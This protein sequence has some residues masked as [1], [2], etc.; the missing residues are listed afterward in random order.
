MVKMKHV[1]REMLCEKK[2]QKDKF[3]GSSRN[4]M[5]QER[6]MKKDD[7]EFDEKKKGK[8]CVSWVNV[9]LNVLFNYPLSKPYITIHIRTYLIL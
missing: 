8:F 1:S 2:L 3:R 5:M 4:S 9:N 6:K 7:R